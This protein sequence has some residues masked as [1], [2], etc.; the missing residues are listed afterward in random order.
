MA[1]LWDGSTDRYS[2]TTSLPPI[3]TFSILAWAYLAVDRNAFTTLFCLGAATGSTQYKLRTSVD[4]TTLQVFNG[5]ASISGASL[6][7]TT[8]T[9]LGLTVA[10]TGSNQALGYVNGA[11]NI[12]A[13]GS[14]TVTAASLQLGND[15]GGDFFNG[16]LAAVKIY[17][18]A[19][20]AI[21]VQQEMWTYVPLRTAN[22]N[23]WY[24]LIDSSAAL[25]AT[26]F[27]G[28][29][30]TWTAAGTLTAADGPPILW[31][32]RP[33][34]APHL[35]AAAPVAH[36]APPPRARPWRIWRTAA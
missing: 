9:H 2:R 5:A 34:M 15:P 25:S 29:G 8:W 30:R 10:G 18:V 3:A 36:F 24:P 27:S 31:S 16:R 4:G 12:T 21:D 13:N 7:L 33:V 11:L 22:L 1:M 23:S 32:S 26:D 14:G 20:S 28:L 19:L 35:G 6:A 17:D